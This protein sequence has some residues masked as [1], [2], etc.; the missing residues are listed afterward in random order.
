VGARLGS[1][2]LLV[3]LT[4]CASML[5]KERSAYVLIRPASGPAVPVPAGPAEQTVARVVSQQNYRFTRDRQAAWLIYVDERPASGGSSA[6]RYVVG[7]VLRNPLSR[8]PDETVQPS[9]RDHQP[10]PSLAM[11]KRYEDAAQNQ[12]TTT[13]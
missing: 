12:P 7:D 9:P 2:A 1:I 4:G 10:H 5:P 8:Y 11:L 13:P 6:P 3:C